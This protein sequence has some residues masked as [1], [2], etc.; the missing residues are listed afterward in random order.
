MIDEIR[1]LIEKYVQWL[2]DK[3]LLREIGGDWV[4]I[5]TP[6]VDRHNDYLQIY[7]KKRNGGFILSDGGYI[8]DDLS[9]SGC[10][11]DSPKRKDLLKM[12]LAGFGVRQNEEDALQITATGDNFAL[13]K[14]NLLQAMLAVNDLFF[15]ASPSVA[16]L[17]Y[18]D[19]VS[20]L[21]LMEIRHTP[22]VKLT[23]RSGYDHMFHFV[24]PKSRTAPE[25]I[26][27]TINRPNRETAQEFA[28]KWIDTR[29][30]RPS[31]SRAYAFLND[32]AQPVPQGV[33]DALQNYE[34]TPV[35][36]SNRDKFKDL[37][38]A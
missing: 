15:L 6:N 21:D 30:T 8:L 1:E 32:Q 28:F 12:T 26:V 33:I 27:E 25:R 24:I 11:L 22:K 31:D 13:K 19:V 17:F 5:T 18:E 2:K 4:E 36:W 9:S 29:E 23:G 20:W 7:A 35:L 16:S 3:T 37:L 38:A 10:K 14:H 34:T